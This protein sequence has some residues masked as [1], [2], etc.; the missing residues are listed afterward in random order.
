[1]VVLREVVLNARNLHQELLQRLLVVIES[2][3]N[4][5]ELVRLHDSPRIALAH[6]IKV[7]DTHRVHVLQEDVSSH[8]CVSLQNLFAG[9]AFV[10]ADVGVRKT[11]HIQ[12]SLIQP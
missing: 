4:A 8:I 5:E 3:D 1:M 11:T 9:L 7:L 6:T 2:L 10:V 12:T